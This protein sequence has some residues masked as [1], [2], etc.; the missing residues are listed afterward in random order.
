MTWGLSP[1]LANHLTT[2]ALDGFGVALFAWAFDT[3]RRAFFGGS[4]RA[5]KTI[6]HGLNSYL[7]F[8]VEFNI[9]RTTEYRDKPAL[10]I[11]G[12]IMGVFFSIIGLSMLNLVVLMD[13]IETYYPPI[14]DFASRNPNLHQSPMVLVF[15]TASTVPIGLFIAVTESS[16]LI[17]SEEQL[18]KLEKR[19]TSLK[20]RIDAR[21]T[22]PKPPG[23]GEQR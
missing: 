1:G 6:F 10:A 4:L 2:I 21:S 3:A 16:R 19:K 8:V 14:G 11:V 9:A 12:V 20:A 22:A 7:L 18:K 23:D 13:F 15:A 5:Y 17:N